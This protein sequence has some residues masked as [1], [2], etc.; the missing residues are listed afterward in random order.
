MNPPGRYTL[1]IFATDLDPDAV[2][3]ARQG[4]Y[5]ANIATDVSEERLRHYFIEGDG[6]Y[7]V[8]KEIREMVVFAP[9]KPD[10]GPAVHQ[11]RHTHLSQPVDLF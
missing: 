6:G 1:Q 10:H 2:D 11:A 4:F 8:G 9:H 5:P 7:R 3:K